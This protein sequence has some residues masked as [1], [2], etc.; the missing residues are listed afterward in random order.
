M[1]KITTKEEEVMNLFWEKGPMFVREMLEFYDEPKPHFNTVSTYVRELEV[2]GYLGH[3][4]Y[5]KNYQYYPLINRE[6]YK[7][8][9]LSNVVDNYFNKSYLSAVSSLVK[10]ENISIDELKQL[11]KDV[12]E[13]NN[14]K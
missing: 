7:S 2:K 3:K 5:G 9:T 8:L 13:G 10:E 4:A 1:K 14:K 6:E 11:I 12:E